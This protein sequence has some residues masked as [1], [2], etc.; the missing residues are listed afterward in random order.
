M[1]NSPPA[2]SPAKPPFSPQT[3]EA[4]EELNFLS[5]I[6][7]EQT[8]GVLRQ[9]YRRLCQYQQEAAF[10]YSP[11][12]QPGVPQWQLAPDLL[13]LVL[14]PPSWK[15]L[16]EAASQR[17]RATNALIRDLYDEQKIIKD[18]IL[19]PQVIYHDPSYLRELVHLPNSPVPPIFLGAV[20]FVPTS[21]G[22]WQI[23]EQHSAIP[24]GLGYLL[25]NRRLVSRAFP[26]LYQ[27]EEL[28]PVSPFPQEIV[29]TLRRLSKQENPYTLLLTGFPGPEGFFEESF[30]ARRMGIATVSPADLL[31]RDSKLFQRTVG[32]LRKVDILV[33]R[34]RGS[35]LD[36]VSIANTSGKGIPGLLSC[37]RAGSVLVVNDPGSGIADNKALLRHSNEII[38]YY[39]GEIPLMK[40][41][42]TYHAADRDQADYIHT[43]GSKL[44]KALIQ[45]TPLMRGYA[46]DR[47]NETLPENPTDFL[48]AHP[49]WTVG[50]DLPPLRS[51]PRL[52]HRLTSRPFFLRLFTLSLNDQQIRVL[53][54]GL[55]LQPPRKTS[56]WIPTDA[57]PTVSK[58]VWVMGAGKARGRSPQQ[59]RKA[60]PLQ[61]QPLGSRSA[62][63]LYWF[64]RYIERSENLS[65][66]LR[67]L[68]EI[69]W[70]DLSRQDQRIYWPLWEA[71]A[72]AN[73]QKSFVQ[74]KSPPSDTLPL[75]KNLIFS[76]EDPASLY[77]SLLMALR[78]AREIREKTSPEIWEVLPQL[79]QPL[80]RSR[81]QLTQL[82]RNQL[83]EICGQVNQACALLIGTANRTMTHDEGWDFFLIGTL[84]ERA[85]GV[86]PLLHRVLRHSC[87]VT[88]QP[89][90]ENPDLT[91]LLRLLSSLDVYRREYRSRA[92]QEQ[93]AELLWKSR[94]A[95]YSLAYCL[96]RIRR[97]ILRIS[98]RPNF[99]TSL[100]PLLTSM[101][102][103]EENLQNIRMDRIF[104][105]SIDDPETPENPTE[106]FIAHIEKAISQQH[107]E[108]E[109]QLDQLHHLLGE[110]FFHNPS[111]R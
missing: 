50:Q 26:E 81:R 40:S 15:S 20:D 73:D 88:I 106:G 34:I 28:E 18:K 71:I 60:P 98:G 65:H 12:D 49:E 87:R 70:D 64:G 13:P 16:S 56:H 109:E 103:Y 36:P 100:N 42:R 43:H 85:S 77:S 52:A 24:F 96:G 79:F 99:R 39:L 55:C 93:V 47:L 6:L 84:L 90:S 83:R 46:R 63:A 48:K 75:S 69:Q 35:M 31:V 94:D 29:E 37:L 54:G 19:S 21:D 3:E 95:P 30:L 110:T 9:K 91:A 32:G 10:H 78:N 104:P 72:E 97:H 38:R 111:P 27:W 80:K 25:Q 102:I 8:P 59:H 107:R 76:P 74:R 33:R 2:D 58:D 86:V 105:F 14:D 92:Y 22:Q 17:I 62:E 41:V 101:E 61:D 67:V 51:W 108:Q 1:K 11:P 7:Q 89:H 57:P 23:L 66:R 45:S 53:P 68:E 4:F 44:R 82:S 5:P